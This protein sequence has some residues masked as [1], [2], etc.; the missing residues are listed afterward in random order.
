MNKRKEKI[1]IWTSLFMIL[2]LGTLYNTYKSY[3]I[4][5]NLAITTGKVINYSFSNNNYVLKF[6]YIVNGEK[7]HGREFT[8][9]FKCDNGVPGCEGETFTVKYS[10]KNPNNSEMDLGKNNNK[11]LTQPKF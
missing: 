3:D 1:V 6:E 11:K 9:F 4:D 2:L 10:S 7:Y 8:S 5:S